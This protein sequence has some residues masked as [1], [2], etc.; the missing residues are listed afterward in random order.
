MN[1]RPGV[2]VNIQNNNNGGEEEVD[3][4]DLADYT[5][6][7]RLNRNR[8]FDDGFAELIFTHMGQPQQN[9]NRGMNKAEV[10]SIKKEKF[11]KKAD[12]KVGEEEKCPICLIEFEDNVEVRK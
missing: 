8:I 12:V 10:S 9:R 1:R 5:N 4:E 11:Q 7:I 3:F 2:Q 6:F